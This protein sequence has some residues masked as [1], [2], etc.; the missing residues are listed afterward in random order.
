MSLFRF[1]KNT[2]VRKA[3]IRLVAY[4]SA[5]LASLTA[6][7]PGGVHTTRI[8]ALNTAFSGLDGSME[9]ME[10]KTAIQAGRVQSKRIFRETSCSVMPMTVT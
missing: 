5:Q 8:T 7:N 3:M 4:T 6:D 2:F 9:D 1:F 10:T